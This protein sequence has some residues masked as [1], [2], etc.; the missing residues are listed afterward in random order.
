MSSKKVIKEPIK[1]PYNIQ[2]NTMTKTVELSHAERLELSKILNGAKF[3]DLAKMGFALEDAK[4]IAH[5]PEEA[6][7]IH[8]EII[9]DGKNI[10]WEEDG[11]LKKIELSDVTLDA[12]RAEIKNRE[13]AKDLTIGDQNLITLS[14]KLK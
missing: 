2:R 11:L 1:S 13:D 6:T 10:K 8:L 9:N 14:I 12:F 7:K 5:T 4:A 3:T